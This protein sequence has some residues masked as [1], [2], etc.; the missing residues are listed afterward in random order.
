MRR[1]SVEAVELDP[2]RRACEP[3][4]QLARLA[5]AHVR[6]GDP[7]GQPGGRLL[8]AADQVGPQA[9]DAADPSRERDHLR[10]LAE[11][12]FLDRPDVARPIVALLRLGRHDGLQLEADQ[13]RAHQPSHVHR[14]VPHPA[15]S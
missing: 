4:Q 9:V 8:L 6:H 5:G 10:Q 12:R 1:L 14:L 15:A 2:R 7:V 3:D 13:L 11:D